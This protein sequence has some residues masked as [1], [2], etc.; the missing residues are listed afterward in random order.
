MAADKSTY[1]N[2]RHPKTGVVVLVHPLEV[3]T[4]AIYVR[5]GW[6]LLV[7]ISDTSGP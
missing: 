3:G 4:A 6:G 1:H 5:H 7:T 2:F